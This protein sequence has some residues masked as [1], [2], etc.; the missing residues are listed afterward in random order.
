MKNDEIKIPKKVVQLLL[1]YVQ[2][3]KLTPAEV[4]AIFNIVR[5]A[6][7]DAE[8][9]LFLYGLSEVYPVLKEYFLYQEG[10]KKVD[11]EQSIKDVLAKLI[12]ADPV[13]ATQVMKSAQEKGMTKEKLVKLYPKLKDFLK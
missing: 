2:N 13:L 4:Y 5:H 9:E 3:N 8:T 7:T 10:T 6:E 1:T 11:F 12:T